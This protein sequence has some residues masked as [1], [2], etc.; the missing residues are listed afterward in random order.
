MVWF[1]HSRQPRLTSRRFLWPGR[2]VNF[3]TAMTRS[4]TVSLQRSEFDDFL[5]APIGDE[6][7]G[8]LLSVISALAR[9]DLDPWLEAASL[10]RMPKETATERMTPLISAL[11]NRTSAN[12]DREAI[13]ARLI[14]LLP[15]PGASS[16][17]QREPLLARSAATKTRIIIF[18]TLMT[19]LLTTQFLTRG[20]QPPAQADSARAP[21]SS[22]VSPPGSTLP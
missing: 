22:M 12:R 18:V 20:R 15:R 14:A 6:K 7:N 16:A 4:A 17:P 9:L 19:F 10:A 13:A 1:L 3:V 2:R 8:M 21:V 11:P 5:F